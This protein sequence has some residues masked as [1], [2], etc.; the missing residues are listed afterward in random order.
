MTVRTSLRRYSACGHRALKK[1][2]AMHLYD[3]C[4]MGAESTTMPC[5]RPSRGLPLRAHS[6]RSIPPETQPA[7][8]AGSHQH[9]LV[10]CA[11]LCMTPGAHP[12][13]AA[14]PVWLKV[15]SMM[16]VLSAWSSASSACACMPSFRVFPPQRGMHALGWSSKLH[17]MRKISSPREGLFT[18]C[19][20]DLS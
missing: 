8:H 17:H 5:T 1:P 12:A 2:A 9:Q 6:P 11:A 3:T 7:P 16:R 20:R 14:S 13:A 4:C 15:C 18:T 10:L 19:M